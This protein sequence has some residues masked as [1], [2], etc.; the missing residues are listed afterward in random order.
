MSLEFT[1]KLE[2]YF[3]TPSLFQTLEYNWFYLLLYTRRLSGNEIILFPKTRAVNRKD[4]KKSRRN[5]R[6]LENWSH[7]QSYR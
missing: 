2:I 4:D 3:G 6:N 5:S 7:A 1:M